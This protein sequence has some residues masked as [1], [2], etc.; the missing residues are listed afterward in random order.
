MTI[1]DEYR[2]ELVRVH[3]ETEWGVTGGTLSGKAVIDFLK[4]RPDLKTILDYGCGRGSLKQYVEENGVTDREWTLYDPAMEQYNNKPTGTFDLVITTDVLE[5][6]EPHMTNKVLRELYDYSDNV[7]LNDIAC[8]YTYRYFTGGPYIG[9]DLH[10][11][12][13]APDVW[14]GRLSELGVKTLISKPYIYG[15]FQVRYL[16]VIE[17]G[18]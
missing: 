2:K 17:K 9:Q 4:S 8:Y 7:L 14:R 3:T 12:I 6:V 5:H 18:K 10:I 15:E 16:S 1:S 13:E 11:N